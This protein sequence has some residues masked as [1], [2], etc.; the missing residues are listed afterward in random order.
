MNRFQRL[1]AGAI[2]A[3]GAAPAA[4]AGVFQVVV[5]GQGQHGEGPLAPV[6]ITW[7]LAGSNPFVSYSARYAWDS[8]LTLV[9]LS[10][11]GVQCVPSGTSIEI[12]ALPFVSTGN[13]QL[14]LVPSFPQPAANVQIN[15]ISCNAGG[16]C[17]PGIY[18][19]LAPS[20]SPDL[21][22]KTEFTLSGVVGGP[23]PTRVIRISNFG[24]AGSVLRLTPAIDAPAT[25]SPATASQHGQGGFRDFTIA[26]PTVSALLARREIRFT[27]NASHQTAT[28]ATYGVTCDIRT[29]PTLVYDPPVATPIAIPATNALSVTREIKISTSGG[30][31]G[32]SRALSCAALAGYSISVATSP[33]PTG[34]TG[35][36]RL[37]CDASPV[38]PDG[39]L[40]CTETPG[41]VRTWPVSCDSRPAFTATPD[42]AT[43]VVLNGLVGGPD[44][45]ATFTVRN[46]GTESTNLVVQPATGLSGGLSV[47][48]STQ[49][50]IPQGTAGVTYTVTCSAAAAFAGT[51]VLSLVHSAAGSPALLSVTCNMR[52]PPTLQYS[53][54]FGTG[55]QVS[56]SVGAAS[57]STPI[58]V[59]TVGGDPGG[60]RSL[61]CS[62][63]S[64]YSVVV[65][66]SP[67]AT[68]SAG[69]IRVG[70]DS[71]NTAP[72]QLTCTE[73]PV[74]VQRIWN[75]TCANNAIYGSTPRP[76]STVGV[77]SAIGETGFVSADVALTNS[78]TAPLSI[79]GCVQAPL[80]PFGQSIFPNP[81][82]TTGTMNISCQ[83]PPVGTVV[84][85]TLSCA[86]NDPT[87]PS[88][89]YKLVCVAPPLTD[90]GEGASP[91][92]RLTSPSPDGGAL[93]GSSTVIAEGPNGEEI[94]VVGAPN[95]GGDG[96]GRVYVYVR[97]RAGG[98]G[99]LADA[100]D[101]P[102]GRGLGKPVAV[103]RAPAN[104]GKVHAKG[105][106]NKFGEDVAISNDGTLIA[107]GAP[108]GGGANTGEVLVFTMPPGGWDDLGDLVPVVVAPPAEP[109]VVAAGFGS[110][111]EFSP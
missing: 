61:T 65:D 82:T 66:Q 5:N 75:L 58:V 96:D 74:A 85:R 30:Q 100:K 77:Y 99:A 105:I 12:V 93:L 38:P 60:A 42:L 2:L 15:P 11:G 34:S 1:L 14:V 48:P 49:Q 70:C 23:S 10:G 89:I 46:T 109:G 56:A 33:F 7:D 40:S 92:E 4:H 27:H 69:A 32:G 20:F 3:L 50:T 84:I 18:Q 63:P 103:L 81:I 107:V 51:Q 102:P 57:T 87:R 97:Q 76:S 16:P 17:V 52:T 37:G 95:G 90:P 22:V 25:I 94:V 71:I 101:K 21:P 59:T 41:S 43:P 31:A 13:C 19:V 39:T 68:G 106:G 45:T 47:T 44:Q 98:A 104:R 72:G 79:T 78:G 8:R 62:A 80:P 55:V 36:I 88:V 111:V 110:H 35:L 54:S 28:P 67:F 9:G 83:T 26:C 64:N 24:S 86:T 6:I 108:T 29:P 73:S 53:P 91:G